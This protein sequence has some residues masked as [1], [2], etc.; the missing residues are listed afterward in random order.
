MLRVANPRITL[1]SACLLFLSPLASA[2]EVLSGPTLNMDPNGVTPLA[3]QIDLTTDVPTRVTLK[4]GNNLESWAIQFP[5]FETDHAV[6]LLG[7][8]PDSSYW[9]EVS[10]T[11]PGGDATVVSPTLFAT[12]SP[13]PADFPEISVL[14]KNSQRM[15]PGFTLMDR[16][17][18]FGTPGQTYSIAVDNGGNVRW[19]STIGSQNGVR[20][21]PNGRLLQLH[22]EE[23]DML[24]NEFIPRVLDVPGLLLHHD[25]FPMG[26]G[27]YLSL[28]LDLETVEDYPTSEFD[29][30]APP[31]T[32][33]IV[34]D[35]VVEFLPDGSQANVWGL[36]GI[37]D[38][39]RIGYDSTK[40]GFP[41]NTQPDW[42]H[43]NAV[44]YD[45]TDDSIVVSVRHQD[46]VVKFSRATGELIWILGT[47]ANW[48][49]EFQ[50]FLLT[51]VGEP[52]EWQYHQHAIEYTP[53][54]TL[55]LFD[56]G[57]YRASP[58][59]GNFPLSDNETFSRVVEYA[60]DE[61]TKEIRQVWQFG[62]DLGWPL[63]SPT[64]G[65][66]DFQPITGNV[67]ITMS[68][69]RYIAG[70]PSPDWGFGLRHTT[71][72]EVTHDL[73]A[74]KLFDMRVY[75]PDPTVSI[76]HYRSERIPTLYASGVATF[77]DLD[78]DGALI[79]NCSLV[80]NTDQRDTDGD[81]FGN[82]CDPDLDN[83]QVVGHSD[84]FL[85]KEA[86]G[87]ADPD[88]DLDGDGVVFWSDLQLLLDTFDSPPGPSDHVVQ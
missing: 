47:H 10:L 9:V 33:S 48:G 35:M 42:S 44:L 37:I 53:Q 4:V 63:S 31:A 73:P 22:S 66:A 12:T 7:L 81:G 52:F 64:Q 20:Q 56:N 39:Q 18:R 84:L 80:Q 24:G 5:D 77:L 51:P 62:N 36:T 82:A 86:F 65:D 19:Y 2:F 76:W 6:H 16:F 17:R 43:S 32:Q 27:N 59:D 83:D 55:L 54:G 46:A 88:A 21:L 34:A 49:P 68:D 13:L 26:N 1:L 57:N 69:T 45:P 70:Q 25:G 61:T 28:S 75:D 41:L 79:D 60:I 67:L 23:I 71:I 72:L 78:H 30:S 50:P 58:F 15:E 74:Q 87:T 14:Y 85:M 11:E 8:K 38:P 3:G 29:Q 40:G